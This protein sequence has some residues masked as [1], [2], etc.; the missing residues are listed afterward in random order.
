MNKIIK[1]KIDTCSEQ[2]ENKLEFFLDDLRKIKNP[3]IIEFGVR[4]GISTKKIIKICEMNNGFLNAID[5]LDCSKVS[6]S[7]NWKFHQ[8]R[9]DDFEYLDEVLPRNIDLIYLD[10]YHN[11]NHI[12]KIFYHYYDFLKPNG[13]FIFDDISWIPYLSN[14]KRNSFNCE[15]N[16]LETFEKILQISSSNEDLFKLYFSF[17]GSGLCK[18]IK[19]SNLPLNKPQKIKKRIH[20]IKNYLRK[21]FYYFKSI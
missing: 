20:T 3:Q 2:Y 5:V 14:K 21:V 19:K 17:E 15:I 1:K 11:A 10:S 4:F 6:N 8:C 13:F 16:N 9:D 7:K 12:E 18:I